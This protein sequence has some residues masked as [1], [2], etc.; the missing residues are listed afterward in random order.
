MDNYKKGLG[1]NAVPPPHTGLF[2]PPKS[3]VSSTGLEE[4]FNETKTKK[5]KDKSTEVEP[6]SVRKG[7]EV[8]AVKASGCWVWRPKQKD[9]LKL[10][11]LMEVYTKLSDRVLDLEKT[12]TAHAKKIA[13]LKK[14]VKKFERNRRVHQTFY[15][16]NLKKCYAN[17]PLVMP[18]EGV[19]V[20]DRLQFVEEPVEIMERE[21][22]QLKRSRIPLVK[23]HWNSRRGH[24]FT[25]ERKDSFRKKYPHLFTNQASSSTTRS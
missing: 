23:V 4:L 13:N 21:I 6:E 10:K 25:W 12:K 18:L 1:Y 22:K 19:H 24:E 7:N 20:D 8:Y 17:E 2:P 9:K 14:K 5:S 16:S 3:D 11:K 15:V